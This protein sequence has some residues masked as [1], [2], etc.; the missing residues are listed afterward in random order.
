MSVWGDGIRALLDER[1]VTQTELARHAGI[2]RSTLQHVLH[3]GHCGTET[4]ERIAAAFDVSLAELFN[5]VVDIGH[6][7][8]RLIAA[9]LREL[10]DAVSQAVLEDL[11][12]RRKKRRDR[13]RGDVR[14]PF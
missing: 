7:R 4:L 3:G 11:D 14:L 13:P 2:S 6:R 9:V 8:D 1:G 12:R 10:S 5:G